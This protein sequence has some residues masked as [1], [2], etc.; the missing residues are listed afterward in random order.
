MERN[1]WNRDTKNGEINET[2]RLTF[3]KIKK[4]NELLARFI[5]K[6]E[7]PNKYNKKWTRSSEKAITERQ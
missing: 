5:K 3:L 6:K 4:I 2:K 7:G 1:T